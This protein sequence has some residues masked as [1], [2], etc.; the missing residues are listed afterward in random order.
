[1]KI[2]LVE[3]NEHS[4]SFLSKALES[5]NYQTETVKDGQT[6]LELVRAFNYDLI[7][8]DVMLPGLDGI[9]VC[10]Q[11]RQEGF[12]LPIMMITAKDSTSDR[13]RGLEAGADE[14]VV[15]P[16]ELPEL[17]ARVR[18]LLRRGRDIFP[19]VFA[20]E[21][22]QLDMNTKEVSYK[23]KRLHLTP[24]EY[25]LLEIFLRNPDKIFSRHE[26]LNSIWQS[27]ESPGE[28]AVTTQIKGLRQ[29]L[30]A[31]GMTADL[32]ETVY[33]VGYR[34][35]KENEEAGEQMSRG[36]TS[37]ALSSVF[38]S[39][40]S[41]IEA[42][43]LTIMTKAWE[44]FREN[45]LK[46]RFD[47][48]DLALSNLSTGT[49]DIHLLRKAQAEAHCLAGSL[50]SYGLSLGSKVAREIEFLLQILITWK[51]NVALLLNRLKKLT[52]SLKKTLKEQI[53]DEEG[54]ENSPTK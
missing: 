36:E 41:T 15:K 50:G 32:I 26:L 49:P 3:D 1:M 19:M 31:A 37:S 38:P 8:L 54:Q 5:Y 34:L 2:L 21:H 9:S 16:C 44:D 14:Y 42:E 39:S 33:G 12:Q 18:A 4:A 11:L 23:K 20:W 47:L 28:E 35:R 45:F 10:T 27:S 53:C 7:L 51:E 40:S 24:K 6:A 43:V 22:L 29:K 52:T 30:K 48:F 46:E 17:I 13:V 25:G